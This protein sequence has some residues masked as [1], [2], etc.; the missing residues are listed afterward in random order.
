MERQIRARFA[1]VNI[2]ISDMER[3]LAFYRTL[4]VD[5]EDMPEPWTAHH[6]TVNDVSP[7]VAVEFD[8]LESVVNWAPVWHP[9]RTGAV[10][11]FVVQGDED[12]DAA[13][14]LLAA[15]GHVVLQ[16]PHDAFFGARYAVVEDPDG[17]PV[18]IMGPIDEARR[19][20][21]EPPDRSAGGSASAVG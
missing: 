14:A 9:N 3:S 16:P 2:V 20:M 10:I 19:W 17:I 6:R 21:P 8:S 18:G 1:Q 7:A 13:V 15:E 11:G 12:V 4:G 5:V